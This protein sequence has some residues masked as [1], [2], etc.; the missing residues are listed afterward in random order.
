MNNK[1]SLIIAVFFGLSS[2]SS[3][4]HAASFDCEKAQTNIEKLI[5]SDQGLSY[6]DERLNY[7]YKQNLIEKQG[8][9]EPIATERKWLQEI[10][11]SCKDIQC[12]LNKYAERIEALSTHTEDETA[13]ADTPIIVGCD[14][15]KGFMLV[16]APRQ[17]GMQY[18]ETRGYKMSELE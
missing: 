17:S 14:V 5:C 4:A 11:G 3:N 8:S 2:V 12:L 10:R 1:I 16:Q 13:Y 7:E 9:Q 18:Y 15:A 6:F